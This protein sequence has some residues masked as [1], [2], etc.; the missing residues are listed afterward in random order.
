[1]SRWMGMAVLALLGV[2]CG[3]TSPPFFVETLIAGDSVDPTGPFNVNAVVRDDRRVV[4]VRLSYQT[5]LAAAPIRVELEPGDAQDLWQCRIP[6][7]LR[8]TRIYYSLEASDEDGNLGRDPA[9]APDTY[10]F[11]VQPRPPR[12]IEL[13]AG[14]TD[15]VTADAARFDAAVDA[16]V[17]DASGDAGAED[18][19]VQDSSAIDVTGEDLPVLPDAASEDAAIP[20]DASGDV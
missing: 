7:P 9:L 4:W 18:V 20:L 11:A 15:G 16:T 19:V 12:P 5:G 2:G 10:S 14:S 3:D 8:A 13:D 17:E 1:M 6:G